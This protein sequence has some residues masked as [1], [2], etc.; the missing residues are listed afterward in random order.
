MADF[1]KSLK[2]KGVEID[3]A[4][5]SNG[6]VFQYNGTKF[7]PA[8]AAGGATI[9]DTP[10]SSP[11]AGQIW[12]E[13]DTG[14]T[15]VYYDSFWIEI[16]GGST[17]GLELV[18]TQTIGSAVTS[19]SVTNAF[20]SS[21]DSYQITVTGGVCAADYGL[22]MRL[23]STTSGYYYVGEYRLYTNS[24][25]T[26]TNGT[27]LGA[28]ADKWE[29]VGIATTNTLSANIFVNNPFLAKNSFFSAEYVYNHPAGGKASMSGYLADS[30]QYTDFTLFIGATNMTGGTIRVYGYRNT[31]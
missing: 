9:S 14:K 24:S 7:L 27:I 26:T 18:K 20:S 31:I 1:L 6:Q 15:F 30:N 17:S 19:V 22:N 28:N 21:Y 11:S 29:A 23:G 3:T 12:F 10:P 8:N 13:S 2:V 16:G 5:A 4:G 25:A